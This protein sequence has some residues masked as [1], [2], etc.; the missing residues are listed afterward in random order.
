MF[1]SRKAQELARSNL[2]LRGKLLAAEKLLD[3]C[4]KLIAI[5]RDG[6]VNKFTF[7]RNGQQL[8]IETMGLLSDDVN[9]WKKEL[10]E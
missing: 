1:T 3:D 6:R 4:T 5:E 8:T 9:R 10:L 2:E 7:I